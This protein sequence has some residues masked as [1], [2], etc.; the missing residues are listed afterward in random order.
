MTDIEEK[1]NDEVEEESDFADEIKPAA[2][3]APASEAPEEPEDQIDL[4]S[5]EAEEP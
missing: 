4:H 2:E 1:K 5:E 3:P